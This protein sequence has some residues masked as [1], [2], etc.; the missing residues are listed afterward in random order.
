MVQGEGYLECKGP[1]RLWHLFQQQAPVR[2]SSESI[3][4]EEW[5][6]LFQPWW[7]RQCKGPDARS[8]H[9]QLQE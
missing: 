7:E 8:D 4:H 5:E 2:P 9:C 6:I 1:Q 3:G